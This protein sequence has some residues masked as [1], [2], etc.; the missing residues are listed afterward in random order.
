MLERKFDESDE[1]FIA[2]ADGLFVVIE[3]VQAQFNF[4]RLSLAFHVNSLVPYSPPFWAFISFSSSL[5]RLIHRIM[6]RRN[7]P[8]NFAAAALSFVVL[9]GVLPQAQAFYLP[10]AAPRDYL[11]GEVVPVHVNRLNPLIGA[12]DSKIVSWRFSGLRKSTH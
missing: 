1:A 11:A 7:F 5:D 6:P 8:T 12:L 4:A 3:A 9:S 10:G 2:K